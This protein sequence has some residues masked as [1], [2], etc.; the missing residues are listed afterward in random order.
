M[1]AHNRDLVN[2]SSL[3]EMLIFATNN[4][5]R[6]I[7][8]LKTL[9]SEMILFQSYA[10][11]NKFLKKFIKCLLNDRISTF[12]SLISQASKMDKYLNDENVNI[13]N[14]VGEYFMK[15]TQ[16]VDPGDKGNFLYETNYDVYPS[17]MI[18]K[19][20]GKVRFINNED[21]EGYMYYVNFSRYFNIP[22]NIFTYEFFKLLAYNAELKS[23]RFMIKK[24]SGF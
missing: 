13:P 5:P 4:R 7:S 6:K 12:E 15:K 24:E 23:W 18:D 10:E 22:T 1:E 8:E 3:F 9:V 14:V 19:E 20:S 16:I 17:Y 21:E 2:F 11:E